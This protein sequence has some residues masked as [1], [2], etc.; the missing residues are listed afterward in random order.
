MATRLPLVFLL[1]F[2]LALTGDVEAQQ[3]KARSRPKVTQKLVS[4]VLEP[5]D[6]TVV[7]WQVNGTE[8]VHV[9]LH[10]NNKAAGTMEGGDDQVVVSSGGTPNVVRRVVT[11]RAPGVFQIEAEAESDGDARAVE[12]A[13]AFRR[14]LRRIAED[15]RAARRHTPQRQSAQFVLQVIDHTEGDVARSLPYRELAPFRDA[16]A[17]F[18]TE[19]R[20]EIVAAQ[21]RASLNGIVLVADRTDEASWLDRLAEWLFDAS[22]K[23]T[24]GTLCIRTTPVSQASLKFYPKSFPSDVTPVTSASLL[25]LYLGRYVYEIERGGYLSSKSEIDLLLGAQRTVT[26][27]L[28]TRD[29]DPHACRLLSGFQEPCR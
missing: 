25:T 17:A 18:L 26:C 9:H 6:T 10:N 7:E 23:S 1:A 12:I 13:A 3:G 21:P 29:S 2:G 5:G 16:L 27:A 4:R 22:D 19:L 15:V 14:E 24:I 11:A 20:A 8:P 28:R